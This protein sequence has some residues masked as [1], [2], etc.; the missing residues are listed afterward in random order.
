VNGQ[1]EAVL[2][3]FDGVLADTEPVHWQCW[4]DVLR[5]GAGLELSWDYYVDQCIGVSDREMLERLGRIGNPPR[6]LVELWPL[7]PLKQKKFQKLVAAVELIPKDTKQALRAL[8]GIRLA[9]VTSSI[10]S[11]IEPILLRENVLE[12]FGA[13]VYGN[14]V[15]NLKPHPEPYLKAKEML[16]VTRAVVL[17]DSAAGQASG[18]AAG[19]D[20]VEV[21]RAG[22]V[23]TLL[24][25]LLRG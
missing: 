12:L 19:C 8:N 4:R 6:T 17:E 14:T 23:A 20:V 10:Q 5:E 1:Y 21:K 15:S 18:R 3:D 13:C 2:L 24:A 22:E 7:Y 25:N 16:G 9:V 11:E